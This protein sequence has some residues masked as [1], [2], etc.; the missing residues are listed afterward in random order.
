KAACNE[1]HTGP[2]LTDNKFHNVGAPALGFFPGTTMA[3]P[4]NRGRA[5]VMQAILTNLASVQANPDA[6]VYDGAGRYSDNRD[7]GM[8]RLLEV[9]Q[10]DQD[11]CVTRNPMTMACTQYDETLEGAFRTMSLLNV[12]MTAPYFHSG[13]VMSL[14]DVVWQYN[15][16]GGPP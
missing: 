6:V 2:T 1:C 10:E 14:E 16:G 7:L 4:P 12:A 11:H 13:T 8:Q 9:Q 5:G 3:V 15:N